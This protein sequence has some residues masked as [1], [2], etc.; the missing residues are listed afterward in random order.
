MIETNPESLFT[1]NNIANKVSNYFFSNINNKISE[2]QKQQKY[3]PQPKVNCHSKIAIKVKAY[4][5]AS[6]TTK[7]PL[8]LPRPCIHEIHFPTHLGRSNCI[9]RMNLESSVLVFNKEHIFPIELGSSTKSVNLSLVIVEF[10]HFINR[11]V[12]HC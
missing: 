10:Y 4:F 3:P 6:I 8:R 9:L 5:F 7:H 12:P 1:A 2:Q 11:N